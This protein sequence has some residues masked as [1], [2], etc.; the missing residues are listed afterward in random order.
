MRLHPEKTRVVHITEGFEFLG[1]RFWREDRGLHLQ[2]RIRAVQA[3]RD[4]VRWLTRRKQPRRRSCGPVESG[5]S[6]LAAVFPYRRSAETGMA[7]GPLGSPETA[8][9]HGQTRAHRE[10]AA[11]RGSLLLS[12][13]G[14]LLSSEGFLMIHGSAWSRAAYGRSVRAVWQSGPSERSLVRLDTQALDHHIDS[15][16]TFS[17]RGIPR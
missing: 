6:G 14:P 15:D 17:V 7:V 11:I 3:L 12:P 5:A 13:L 16:P 10:L 9:L 8:G 4:K 2:P 1:F